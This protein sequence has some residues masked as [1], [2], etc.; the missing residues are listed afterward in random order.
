MKVRVFQDRITGYWWVDDGD[1]RGLVGPISRVVGGGTA[2][3]VWRFALSVARHCAN[4]RGHCFS[5]RQRRPEA[6]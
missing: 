5:T 4:G 6:S 3:A 2:E 1:P